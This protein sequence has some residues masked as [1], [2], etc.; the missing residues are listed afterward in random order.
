[1]NSV[2]Q[3]VKAYQTLSENGAFRYDGARDNLKHV[4]SFGE[5]DCHTRSNNLGGKASM[6]DTAGDPI[7]S[8][9]PAS[10]GLNYAEYRQK[11]RFGLTDI[12][13]QDN[14]YVA[15]HGGRLFSKPSKPLTEL[16]DSEKFRAAYNALPEE[17]Q[18]RLVDYLR[19]WIEVLGTEAKFEVLDKQNENTLP[20]KLTLDFGT[21]D[22]SRFLWAFGAL[23]EYMA[24]H[25]FPHRRMS[26]DNQED[27]LDQLDSQMVV[28]YFGTEF[29]VR[30]R[31]NSMC[32]RT[33]HRPQLT[34]Y[35]NIRLV[36]GGIELSCSSKDD[37]QG[38]KATVRNLLTLPNPISL[39]AE[40]LVFKG[41]Q[42]TLDAEKVAGE[43]EVARKQAEKERK[44]GERDA[45]VAGGFGEL[46]G[47][48]I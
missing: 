10:Q 18:A 17:D 29:L 48:T 37:I 31:S 8:I 41:I 33:V 43:A 40:D 21:P 4:T 6:S 7:S 25:E 2:D 28:G 16:V 14:M 5:V 20:Y 22:V 24:E 26:Y 35:E 1:M 38:F 15:Y 23:R 19:A 30:G 45:K 42:L 9:C 34:Q 32:Y 13:G 11:R 36:D 39:Q 46:V 12:P 27:Y 47:T 3:A 44:R